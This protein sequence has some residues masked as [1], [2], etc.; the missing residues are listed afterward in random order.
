MSFGAQDAVGGADVREFQGLGLAG[1]LG[2][3]RRS[4]QEC[5]QSKRGPHGFKTLPRK[6]GEHHAGCEA[7]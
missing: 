4:G 1:R 6:K 3:A 5:R 2:L 7:L